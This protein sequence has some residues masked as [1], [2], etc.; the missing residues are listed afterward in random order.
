[1]MPRPF[2]LLALILGAAAA[3]AQTLTPAPATSLT[4]AERDR[5]IA[6]LAE[7]QQEFLAAIE[8]LTPEQWKFKAAPE[9]WSIAET[10]EHIAVTEEMVWNLL[11]EKMMKAP[12]DAAKRAEVQGKD[13]MIMKMVPDRSKKVTAPEQLK[14]TGRWAT[15]Q[16]MVSHFKATRAKEMAYLKETNEDLRSH[17]GEHPLFKILDGYQWLLLNGAHSKRHTAQILEVKADP[18]FPKG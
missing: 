9:R 17:F 15:P 11:T 12:A 13:E 2:T 3:V 1:M 5:A 7:T 8:G 4:Q 6:Y 18:G 16:E 10:A 14:P